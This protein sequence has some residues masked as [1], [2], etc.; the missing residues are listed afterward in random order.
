[1][2]DLISTLGA[3]HDHFVVG[4]LDSRRRHFGAHNRGVLAD[5]GAASMAT[6]W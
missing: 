4:F 5:G 2:D 3:K 6:T 1:M